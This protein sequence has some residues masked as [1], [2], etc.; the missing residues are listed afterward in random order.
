MA[1]KEM[2]KISAKLE[3]KGA[4]CGWHRAATAVKKWS[5]SEA[6][7]HEKKNTEPKV[8][9]TKYS[10]NKTRLSDFQK[11][12]RKLIMTTFIICAIGGLVVPI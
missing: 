3:H 9:D 12:D 6:A 4:K 2:E 1:V 10:N 5:L 7:A 8:Y 11:Q